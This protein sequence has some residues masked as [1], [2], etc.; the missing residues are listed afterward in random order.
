LNA[1]LQSQSPTREHDD[2]ET[3]RFDLLFAAENR[4]FWF[5]GRI[6]LLARVVRELI[7]G[8]TPGYRVM[9]V[10]CGTGAVLQMLEKVCTAGQVS[11][12]D[13][14]EEGLEFARRRVS[15]PLICGDLRSPPFDTT[16][17]LVGMFDV[18]EH[19]EDD[20][21]T[22][23]H[24]FRLIRPDGRLLLTVPAHTSLWSY[25]D[26]SS[27]HYRRYHRADLKSKLAAAGFEVEFITEFMMTLFPLVWLGRRLNRLFG[28][29]GPAETTNS[30]L[31][32]RGLRVVPVINTLLL[33]LLRLENHFIARRW[34][35][36]IG[37]S[38]L[39]IARRP[40]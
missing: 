26:V 27:G 1:A 17:D 9:E 37:T 32:Q 25:F 35:L 23:D 6:D 7:A 20:R 31:V 21:G 12:M 18:L 19:I 4:H 14:F 3:P 30:S 29:K 10:G 13:L 16:F 39:A 38:L 33:W 5:Q 15:C 22:L 11:G 36:P 2:T 40:A 8:L 28:R 24:L 34:S